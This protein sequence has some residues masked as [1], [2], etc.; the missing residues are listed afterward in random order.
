VSSQTGISLQDQ[1][2]TASDRTLVVDVRQRLVVQL[3]NGANNG[4][5]STTGTSTTSATTPS[6]VTATGT[7]VAT[8]TSGTAGAFSPASVAVNAQNGVITLVGFV[9]NEQVQQQVVNTAQTTPGVVRVVNQLQV[10]PELSARLSQNRPNGGNP[11]LS[12][13]NMLNPV[14]DRALGDKALIRN[15]LGTLR[16]N[17]NPT[18]FTNTPSSIFAT[19]VVPGAPFGTTNTTTT[20][21]SP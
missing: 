8:G 15:Q 20:N 5:T 13:T 10:N 11:A 3:G 21:S 9:P 2:I 18:G 19:N 17:L 1:A 4:N 7:T 12:A 14:G 6:A 16:T